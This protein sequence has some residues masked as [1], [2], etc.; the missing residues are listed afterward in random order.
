[1]YE[2]EKKFVDIDSGETVAYIEKGDPK[3]D[4]IVILHGNM[5]SSVSMI[6]LIDRICD[7]LHCIAP[8]LRGYGDS[9][10]NSEF[11]TL[12]ELAEDVYM[13]CRKLG[14]ESAHFAGWSTATPISFELAAAHPDMVKSIF[15]IEGVSHMGQ[16]LFPRDEKGVMMTDKPYPNYEAMEADSKSY[17]SHNIFMAKDYD[18]IRTFWNKLL[19]VVNRPADDEFEQILIENGKE[20]C[21]NNINWAWSVENMSNTPTEYSKGDDTIKLVKCPVTLTTGEKD[22]VVIREKMIENHRAIKQ[23][24]LLEYPNCGHVPLVDC[25]DRLAADVLEHVEKANAAR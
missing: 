9:S 3:N 12:K 10:Y 25:P 20:R 16:R 8:D 22:F 5:A 19:Y 4:T 15:G 14:I 24:V 23:S 21:Q 2:Y 1:M 18:K 13:F 7:K 11:R 6:P 17:P